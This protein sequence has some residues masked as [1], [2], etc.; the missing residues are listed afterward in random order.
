MGM[1]K[2]GKCF[3]ATAAYGSELAKEV[4]V[5]R[6]FRDERL[7]ST[8]FGRK[9]F[10]LYYQLSPSIAEYISEHRGAA[11]IARVILRPIIAFARTAMRE[12]KDS[13]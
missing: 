11:D 10:Q 13:A 12:K 8:I 1:G 2:G 7:C 4:Q 5:L 9:L 6:G 3:I